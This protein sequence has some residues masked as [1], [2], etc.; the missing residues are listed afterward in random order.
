[1]LGFT[2]ARRSLSLGLR[3][4]VRRF[5]GGCRLAFTTLV[6]WLVLYVLVERLALR[7]LGGVCCWLVLSVLVE[8]LALGRLGGVC[9][10]RRL[11]GVCRWLVLYVLVE[12]WALRRLGGVCRL[13]CLVRRLGGVCRLACLGDERYSRLHERDG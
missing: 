12:R 13:A 5:G 2:T 9:Q 10:L 11:G 6:A 3:C 7:R 1:M 8:R 4:V